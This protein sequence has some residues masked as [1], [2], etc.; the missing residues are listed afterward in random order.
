MSSRSAPS[1]STPE[2][3]LQVRSWTCLACILPIRKDAKP[4]DKYIAD[5]AGGPDGGLITK[6]GLEKG[7]LISTIDYEDVYARFQKSTAG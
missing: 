4:P 2:T 3:S 5:M 6:M 7:K 1:A